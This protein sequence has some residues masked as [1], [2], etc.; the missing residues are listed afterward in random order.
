MDHA[1]RGGQRLAVAHRVVL[2]GKERVVRVRRPGQAVQ[3]IV[4]V[5]DHCGRD[6]VAASTGD[7]DI[8]R[9]RQR[10]RA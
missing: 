6:G 5:G 7:G 2:V 1:G 8:V 3:R 9:L 4:G 10:V